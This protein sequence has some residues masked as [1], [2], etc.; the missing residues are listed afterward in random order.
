MHVQCNEKQKAA[1]H[2]ARNPRGQPRYTL[3][4]I[5]RRAAPTANSQL[6]MRKINKFVKHKTHSNMHKQGC[7]G[8]IIPTCIAPSANSD[9]QML[10]RLRRARVACLLGT[11]RGHT[12][13]AMPGKTSTHTALKIVR[14]HPLRQHEA[15]AGQPRQT[16]EAK[17]P[18][19]ASCWKLEWQ[20]DPEHRRTHS[21]SKA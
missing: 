17:P 3:G 14:R 19:R 4:S 9:M 11:R 2:H 20:P 13:H 10:L 21:H 15:S 18:P 6:H 16:T 1:A 12:S 7:S 5:A 8:T